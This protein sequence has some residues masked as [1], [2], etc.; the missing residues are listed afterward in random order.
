VR[1][2]L[3]IVSVAALLAAVFLPDTAH[4]QLLPE[5]K[6]V[7]PPPS[8]TTRF[9]ADPVSDG[10]V[11]SISIGFAG[12]LETIIGTQELTPQQPG[13]TSNLIAMDEAAVRQNPSATA[14][15]ISNYGILFAGVYSLGDVIETTLVDGSQAGLV[16]FVIY[17]ESASITWATTNLAKI[18]VRRPRPGAYRERDERA[19]QG[20]PPLTITSTNTAL[21]FFSGHAAITAALSTTATYLAFA[22]SETPLRGYLTLGGGTLLTGLVSWGRVRGG[23]HFPTDVIAGAMAGIGVGA[24]VPHLHREEQPKE[25]PIWIGSGPDGSDYGLTLN[26]FL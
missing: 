12:L 1:F 25:R 3:W 23:V 17:A 14:R 4:A 8:R 2:G 9:V 16:D 21:S 20:L 6:P 19:E 13:P 10:A 26:G 11:L 24:L 7:E 22:R 15:S 5:P 18:A